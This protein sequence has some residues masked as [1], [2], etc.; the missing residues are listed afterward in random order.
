MKR[1]FVVV[2]QNAVS[3]EG[4]FKMYSSSVAL[5]AHQAG[6]DVTV[7]WNKRFPLDTNAAP[8]QTALTFSFTEAEAD[9]QGILPFGEGHFGYEL[10]RGLAP[11]GLESND[12]V[13]VHTSHFVELVELLEY[14]VGVLPDDRLP[15]FHIV[16]R[17]D[18]DIFKSR[19]GRLARLFARIAQSELLSGKIRFHSDTRLLADEYRKLFQRPFGVCPIPIRQD[20]LLPI[21]E[22]MRKR[23]A[24]CSRPLVIS[25]LGAARSE[26]GY[27]ELLEAIAY[28]RTEYLLT[29][30]VHFIL[31]CS[32]SSIRSETG[33]L[34]Y[35][36][37]LEKYIREH[38]LVQQIR[39]I[40]ETVDSNVYYSTLAQS[41]IVLAGYSATS[42]RYRS[43]SV[44]VEAMAAGKVV[45][46]TQ[47]SWMA[48][49]VTS[50]H[51]VI[52]ADSS[53]LGSA[54]AGAVDRF[55]ELDAGAK[56]RQASAISES[57]ATTLMNY[58]IGASPSCGSNR[59]D[60]GA[61][62]I[63]AV[64][65]GVAMAKRNSAGRVFSNRLRYFNAAGYRVA[66]LFVMDASSTSHEE[67]MRRL[68][69]AL[70]PHK[71]ERIFIAHSSID[72]G[73]GARS[74]DF[75]SELRSFLHGTRPDCVFLDQIGYYPVI[76][77]LDLADVST[78]S[79][80]LGLRSSRSGDGGDFD[81]EMLAKCHHVISLN[82]RE[83][84]RLRAREPAL[85]I[86]T[87]GVSFDARVPAIEALAGVRDCGE[88]VA[89]A[90]PELHALRLNVA[91][92]PHQTSQLLRLSRLSSVDLLFIVS[93]D[94]A[95]ACSLR[96]FLEDV[97][98]PFL[99]DRHVSLIVV[100]DVDALAP[101]PHFEEVVFID[102]VDLLDPLY[103]AAK[104]VVLPIVEG[105]GESIEVYEA[106]AKCKPVVAT[107][108]AVRDF[109]D[110]ASGLEVHDQAHLFANAVLRLLESTT[111][112]VDAA[113]HSFQV[114]SRLG[115]FDCD[116]F[117]RMNEVFQSVLG[118]RAKRAT[119]KHEVFWSVD[120]FIEWTPAIRT[121]NRV[122]RG[123]VAGEPI[124]SLAELSPLDDHGL[125]LVK[126][127]AEC[128][129]EK[130]SAFILYADGHLFASVSGA[131]D[132]L[133]VEK[134]VEITRVA[135]NFRDLPASA[136]RELFKQVVINRRFCG[137]I[138][139]LAQ[140][141]HDLDLDLGSCNAGVVWKGRSGDR[142]KAKSWEF[143]KDERDNSDFGIITLPACE[144]VDWAVFQ[145]I[146]VSRQTR[147]LGRRVFINWQFVEDD[148]KTARARILSIESMKASQAKVG[149]KGGFF[150]KFSPGRRSP[151]EKW[152][153]WAKANP[154]FD[155]DW[156]VSQ[157]PDIE[158]KGIAPS[159]HYDRY[160]VYEGRNP[161]SFF[162]TNW[163]F[164]R[165]PE[166][167]SAN[168]NPLNHYLEW[169][170][171]HGY[172]PCPH[173]SSLAYF[174]KNPDIRK[175]KI[176]PL[177]HYLQYGRRE[178]RALFP[179]EPISPPQNI[180]LPIVTGCGGSVW[181][182]VQLKVDSEPN[183]VPFIELYCNGRKL[184]LRINR[185]GERI[186]VRTFVS[187][188]DAPQFGCLAIQ[189]ALS[190]ASPDQKV[191][192][193]EIHVGWTSG[194][195]PQV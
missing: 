143:S 156:Y 30:R 35:Q 38:N 92:P 142:S 129:L 151:L 130:R 27:C 193:V 153:P 49:C 137:R 148:N 184:D 117:E 86:S 90:N 178:G 60:R 186:L 132:G 68:A 15:Y 99:A 109:G 66:A 2:D 135:Q 20:I 32:S 134:I 174:D 163:Y 76:E 105:G 168:E 104:I 36:E 67:W 87:C 1:R 107:K 41:D 113:N 179:A 79:E 11:L 100:G 6:H 145:R 127:V 138:M 182:E 118:Q 189:V 10:E 43:S 149:R 64:A 62:L 57:D 13:F 175:W 183:T 177:L 165:Y 53:A 61:P 47:R 21:L 88:L 16:L 176:N 26:K 50:D 125:G 119:A 18:P 154:L 95:A 112:R 46:T 29:N 73:G 7:L 48:S 74:F 5:A 40:K 44:L 123:C 115:G 12:I 173:F 160:G 181:L 126:A 34:E 52:Y 162:D 54:I 167:R 133:S 63:F 103:A 19:L 101:F 39:L 166:V 96:W 169:G 185:S 158:I 150:A 152:S 69:D 72:P 164:D 98:R 70:Q 51:A 190:D 159:K 59:V 195:Y 180:L 22:I 93:T 4:H 3:A 192:I 37:S 97:Y 84:R 89:I 33:L 80:A 42:Y 124:D 106:L 45:V 147:V 121:A 17:Y 146:P 14:L 120:R 110:L 23:T 108:V 140:G 31:Q 171:F 24:E 188:F 82:E 71:C 155:A 170:G 144:N 65:D 187:S 58:L 157:Y 91:L 94:E 172:D 56:A 55:R 114:A 78:I 128:L 102:R 139:A 77:A 136:S 81:V 116:Y 83:T 141:E 131:I 194:N 28:L 191:E 8:Y 161:N 75:D 111:M 25:Y 85:L 122:V 9:A